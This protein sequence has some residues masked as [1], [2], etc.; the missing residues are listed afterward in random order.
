MKIALGYHSVLPARGGCETYIASL[1]RRLVVDGHQV[2]LF[3]SQWDEDAL[4][5]SICY[6]QI[7]L[8]KLPRFLRHWAFSKACNQAL[9]RVDHDVSIGFDKIWGTDILYPQGGLYVASADQNVLKHQP[10]WQQMAVRALKWL[11]LTHWS[12]RALEHR[13][14]LGAKR[15]LIIAIS[16]MVQYHFQHYYNISPQDLRVVRI[17]TDPQ[18]FDQ[19]DRPRRR[20]EW[21]ESWGIQSHELVGLFVGMNYRLKGLEPLLKAIPLMPDSAPF[22]L[23]V[24]GGNQTKRYERMA[25]RLGISRRVIF[26]G[27]TPEIRNCYFASDFLVH[28]T[29]YDPCSH[30]VPE[31]MACGLPIITTRYNGAAE[32]MKPPKEGFVINDPHDH[33][34]LASCMTQMMDHRLRSRCGQAARITGSQWT[35]EDHYRQMMEVL[36]EAAHRRQAA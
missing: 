36:N 17:A 30:V 34:Q 33:A 27:Y 28:P 32:L 5:S 6:H 10:K 29:F 14:Y 16:Q 23:L 22:R 24:V 19:Q 2:H 7:P 1:A 9:S 12:Y 21:R 4:P 8:P 20:V 31:A 11:N 3:A 13:Q 26:A 18:R 35:F 15:P 25:Q